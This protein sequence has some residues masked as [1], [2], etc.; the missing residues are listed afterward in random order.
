M[1]KVKIL[2][3]FFLILLFVIFQK[4]ESETLKKEVFIK[5]GYYYTGVNGSYDNPEKKRFFKGFYIDIHP[6]TNLEYILFLRKSGYKT[7]AKF[8]LEKA[9]K[10]P[11]LPVTGLIYEDCVAFSKFFNKSLP[12]EWEWE[13]AARS[14]K[15]D[16]IYVNGRISSKYDGNFLSS[17]IYRKV[18]VMSYKPNEMGIYGMEGNIYEWTSGRYEQKYM[19]GKIPAGTDLRVIRGGSWTNQPYDVKT[20]VRTPFPSDRSLNWLGFR[21]IRYPDDNIKSD[22]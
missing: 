15:K 20:T 22:K 2:S 13:I 10:N 7:S 6:V 3:I 19:A 12:S 1:K 16:N 17:R 4:V 9:E 14:L 21:C 5:S 18:K 11:D 8:D